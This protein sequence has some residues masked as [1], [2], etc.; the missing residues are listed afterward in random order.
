[1]SPDYNPAINID[2]DLGDDQWK[3]LADPNEIGVAS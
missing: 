2:L 1:M 3:N